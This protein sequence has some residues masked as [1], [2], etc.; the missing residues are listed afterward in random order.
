MTAAPKSAARAVLTEKTAVFNTHAGTE[1]PQNTIIAEVSAVSTRLA[2]GTPSSSS[3]FLPNIRCA[4]TINTA[5][6][7]IQSSIG[8]HASIPGRDEP[9]L[10]KP[11]SIGPNPRS[12]KL[13]IAALSVPGT[14]NSVNG[15]NVIIPRPRW[16]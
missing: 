6:K 15:Q 10:Q 9:S 13:S 14:R 4:S 5:V 11:K 12:F 1:N 8:S 7:T 16:G 2:A 3:F